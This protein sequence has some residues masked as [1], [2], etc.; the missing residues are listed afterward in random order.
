MI[1]AWMAY[2]LV[3]ALLVSIAAFAAERIAI[4][5]RLQGRWI[6]VSALLLSLMLDRK[7]VV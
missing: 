1:A 5:R 2:A 3:I 6:W 4:L 7:S